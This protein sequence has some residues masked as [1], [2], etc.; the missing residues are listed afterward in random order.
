[1]S[2]KIAESTFQPEKLL[3]VAGTVKTLEGKPVPNAKVSL[4]S[5]RQMLAMDTVAD[6][7]GD[8]KFDNLAITDTAKLYL[9][10]EKANKEKIEIKKPDYPIITKM[11]IGGEAAIV[12]AVKPE[13][14]AEMKKQ[15]EEISGNMKT[16]ITLKQVDIKADK[17]PLHLTPL[18]HSDN[19]NGAGQANQVIMGNKLVGCPDIATCLTSLLRGGVRFVYGPGGTPIIYSTHTAI[20]LSGGTKP[21]SVLLDGV[22]MDQSVLKSV[23]PTDIYSIEVLESHTYTAIYGSAAY[24]GLLVITTKRGDE[25]SR[26]MS[27]KPGLTI[28]QF[29]GYR[30]E[31]Q[32]YSPQYYAINSV[33]K[34]ENSKTIYWNPNALSNAVGKTLFD[35]FDSG[36]KRNYRVIVEGIDANGN[37]GRLHHF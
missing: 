32:F 8:F 21:M 10:P 24:G 28:Y 29:G 14:V 9:R 13:V 33:E 23:S 26:L 6:A 5:I 22:I 1:L 35:Y 7:N 25:D 11:R 3:S 37:I 4:A 15:Y 17:N 27:M 36:N 18:I 12:P 20:A 34:L 19:L 31:R 16:G 30:K 2:N